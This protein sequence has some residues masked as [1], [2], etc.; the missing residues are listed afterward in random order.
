M[1]FGNSETGL[2]KV[3]DEPAAVVA[4]HAEEI[5][6]PLVDNTH[7]DKIVIQVD[8]S[9]DNDSK[10]EYSAEEQKQYAIAQERK[11]KLAN[12]RAENETLRAENERYKQAEVRQNKPAKP[13]LEGCDYDEQKYE[14]QMQAFYSQKPSEPKQQQP[15]QAQQQYIDP[16]LEFQM[17][18]QEESLRKSAVD[19]DTVKQNFL[20]QSASIGVTD[21]VLDGF[22]KRICADAGID[23]GKAIYAMSR[24]P[25]AVYR[26][27]NVANNPIQSSKILGEYA[28]K[29]AFE[30]RKKIDAQPEPEINSSGPTSNSTAALEKARNEWRS[31]PDNI[32]KSNAYFELQR[33]VNEN[34]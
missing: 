2:T 30:S 26:L 34:G 25:A 16:N 23:Y 12:A 17:I 19:Y 33:K 1:D 8:E 27:N 21:D 22:V 20:N 31:E 10:R 6:Q 15:Q 29:V 9:P 5:N 3:S 24:D 13:T 28:S 11:R 7:S 32:E 14:Q 18:K 4:T